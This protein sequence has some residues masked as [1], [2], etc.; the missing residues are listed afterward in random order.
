MKQN[1]LRKRLERRSTAI[2]MPISADAERCFLE[3][4][5]REVIEL[6]HAS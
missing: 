6:D 3:A 5:G 1:K 4:S 2:I